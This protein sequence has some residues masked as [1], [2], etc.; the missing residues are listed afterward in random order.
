MCFALPPASMLQSLTFRTYR[1]SAYEIDIFRILTVAPQARKFWS[2]RDTRKPKTTLERF[3]TLSVRR[4]YILPGWLPYAENHFQN[5]LDSK[6]VCMPETIP[7]IVWTLVRRKPLP[8]CFGLE[9]YA[10][11]YS[12]DS[13]NSRTPKTSSGMPWT[14]A[15]RRKLLPG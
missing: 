13:L 12:M 8:G 14:P 15:V 2:T 7:G 10:G 6:D 9:P 4:R 5:T 1:V 3:W 11:N